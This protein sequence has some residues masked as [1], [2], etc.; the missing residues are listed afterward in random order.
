MPRMP[1]FPTTADECKSLSIA[2]LRESG[3]LRPG[4]HVTTLRFSCNGQPTGSVG[5]EVNLV[6]DTTPYVRLHYTLDKTKNYDYRIPLEA[7][8]SNLPGHG[9]RTGR[10]Q[11]RCP[12]SGR[13][14]TILYLREGSGHFAHREAYTTHRLYYDSQLTP[15][16]I[17][18]L[19][20]PYAIERKLEDAYMARYKKNRKTHYR[21]KPTR[22]YAQLLKLEAKADRATQTGLA[23]IQ[24]GLF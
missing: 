21:G 11:F 12:V 14:A 23:H 8:A 20:A 4:F 10:Y 6:A 22:W 3:L 1:N 24:N 7:L 2:F 16:S 5:L 9:H 13:G 15:T 18:A 17:R 19:V